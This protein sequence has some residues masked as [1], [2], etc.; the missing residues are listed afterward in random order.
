MLQNLIDIFVAPGAV[1]ERLKSHP[2]WL[3]PLLLVVVATASI[4][5]GYVTT[6]DFNYLVDQLI[7]QTLA[8]NPN[9]RA[10]EVRAAMGNLNPTLIGI[11]GSVAV[12]VIVVVINCI[13]AGYLS[14]LNKFS[15]QE[16]GYRHWLSLSAWSG[17]PTLFAALA[18]WVVMLSSSNGQVPQSAL[19]PLSIDG[20]LNLHSNNALLQNLSLPQ[21]WSMAL[22]V[23]GYRHFTGTNWTRASI[24]TLAPYAVIY[25][26]WALLAFL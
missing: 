4:Q 16:F 6:T 13:Y 25:G 15:V 3:L 24:A 11:S 22:L 12:I 20:L 8:S 23:V 14:F 1:F 10:S 19:Q 26:I 9:A 17:M 18:A 5:I 7:E 2:H 21:F